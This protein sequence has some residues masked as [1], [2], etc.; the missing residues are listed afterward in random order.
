[1]PFC[2]ANE[3][4]LLDHA[5]RGGWCTGDAAIGSRRAAAAPAVLTARRPL[6]GRSHFLSVP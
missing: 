2:H 4:A 5:V 1:M 6:R 3:Q